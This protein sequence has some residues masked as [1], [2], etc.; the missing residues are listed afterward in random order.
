[1]IKAPSHPIPA[2]QV[3]DPDRSNDRL[4]RTSEAQELLGGCSHMTIKR[5]VAN[6]TADF[7]QPIYLGRHPHFWFNDVVRW[8]NRQAAKPRQPS[9]QAR[10][11]AKAH[12]RR[13]TARA[14]AGHGS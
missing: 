6:P 8:I 11:I 13:R 3:A 9:P 12:A 2:K 5:L 4:I 10:N 14:E 7:P 1:M